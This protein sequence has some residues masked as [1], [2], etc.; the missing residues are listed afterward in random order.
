M[1]FLIFIASAVGVFLGGIVGDRIGRYR[2]I[3]I[4]VLGPLPFTLILPYVDLFW[5]GVLS[6]VIAGLGSIA[7]ASAIYIILEFNQPYSGLFRASSAPLEQALAV[8]GKE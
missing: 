6:V 5:T 3:W 1:L 2:I 8:M 4:S 7:V